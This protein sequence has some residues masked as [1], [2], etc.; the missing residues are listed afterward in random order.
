MENTKNS[1]REALGNELSRFG[2]EVS[3]HLE[4]WLSVRD[5]AAFRALE[6]EVAAVAGKLADDIV[7]CIL[8]AI[9]AEPSL[10]AEASIA[11]RQG[12]EF[13]DG[14]AR[15]VGVTLLHGKEVRLKVAYVRP[16]RIGK[17][18]RPRKV[19]KRGK[20]GVGFYPVLAVLGIWF[21]VT[22]ALGGEVCRQ[23]T[24]S[25]SV[26][27]GRSALK[28]R[29]I[30]LGHKR[31]LR[32]VNKNA[33]RLVEERDA[34]LESAR[35]N[36]A[37]S[38]PLKGKRVVV[39]TDGGR[40]RER[41]PER[42]GRPRK[43]GHRRFDAPWREP[44]LLTIYVIDE[45]G[46]LEDSFQPVYDGTL[47][48]ADATFDMLLGYLKAL[49]AHEASHLTI[50][51][52]GA[53]WIWERASALA[54]GLGLKPATQVA[55]VIDWCHATSVLSEIT[56]VPASWTEAE[57]QT[58]LGL[59]KDH[60]YAGRTEALL[61][62]IDSLAVGRRAKKINEHRD[63]F[64]RNA[65]RMQYQAFENAG[66]PTG[67]G[68]IE[69]AVRRIIN[70]RLKSNGMFWL[71]VNAEGMILLRSYLKSGYLDSIFDWSLVAAVPWWKSQMTGSA[72]QA[73]PLRCAEN[74]S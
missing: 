59:A 54:D 69:S 53:V 39:A 42:R 57:R 20:G 52:D 13:R 58:W 56:K 34:W 38:G 72:A 49:G 11:G 19:G 64:L 5:P 47:G 35:T 15:D 74:L 44:K 50:L 70:M 7:A 27:A 17:P 18:G 3:G 43:S 61:G 45:E 31:T 51:G 9:V 25:D 66:I 16:N 30:D 40:L 4:R 68:A 14:G 36:P 32:I 28:R 46:K 21:G 62:L 24:D 48:D 73:T 41:V 33:R 29:G 26:R 23:V 65:S 63:Y 6:L 8:R 2:L 1:T 37:V 67:S 22:P 12:G 55:Q 10:Q 60:L 71:E